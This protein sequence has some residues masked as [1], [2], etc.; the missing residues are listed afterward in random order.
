[1]RKRPTTVLPAT[2]G[3]WCFFVGQTKLGRCQTRRKYIHKQ[4]TREGVLVRERS[5]FFCSVR[6]QIFVDQLVSAVN[7]NYGKNKHT[8]YTACFF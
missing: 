2:T 3:D 8:H 4:R 1:M 7:C 5:T 6:L